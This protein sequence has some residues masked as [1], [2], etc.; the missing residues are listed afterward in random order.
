MKPDWTRLKPNRPLDPGDAA[1][2]ER[3]DGAPRLA[4][5]VVTGRSPV[6]VG[7]AVGVGK[8]TELACCARALKDQRIACLVPLDRF[9]NMRALT[10][11]GMQLRIAARLA[12]LAARHL[13]LPLTPL[14]LDELERR[15]LI[16]RELAPQTTS[17]FPNWSAE[18]L[19]LLVLREVQRLS[20]QGRVTLLLDGLEKTVG[21]PARLLF[22]A[23]ERLLPEADL[24]VV[25]PFQFVYGE[26]AD[27]VL[28]PGEKL[29]TIPPLDVSGPNGDVGQAFFRAM[30]ALRLGLDLKDP[31]VPSEFSGSGGVVEVCARE[32]GGIPRTFLQ[33]LADAASYARIGGEDWP[34]LVHVTRAI[35]EQRDSFRRLLTPGDDQ[36]LLS[37][38]GTDGRN[39]PTPQKLRLLSHGLLLE[40]REEGR[41]V[42]RSHPIVEPLLH[43]G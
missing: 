30:T 1:Y 14:V 26:R 12:Y 21:E 6:L 2:V 27:I 19:L 18:E 39:L 25:V 38:E 7:G 42:M 32:S 9:E 13:N 3:P 10:P 11:E 4:E 37:A 43:G 16:P 31:A 22:D 29:F 5:W 41:P 8:S 23:L 17:Q 34:A 33:L 15:G 28:S 40:R 36:A 35:E 20:K 24:V